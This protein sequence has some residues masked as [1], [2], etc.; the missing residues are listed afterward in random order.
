M[1]LVSFYRQDRSPGTGV[2]LPTG[3]ILDLQAVPGGIPGDMAALLGEPALLERAREALARAERHPEAL[4]DGGS[5]AWAPAVP[6]PGKF[7]LCGRNY[8][9]HA[10]E[11]GWAPPEKPALFGR[12]ASSLLGAGQPIR[13]PRVDRKVDWEGELVAVIGRAGRYIGRADAMQHVAGLTCFN[14]VSMRDYQKNLPHVTL[15]KNFDASG[16]LGPWVTTL[17]E[18][19]DPAALTLRTL[20][21]GEVVQEG[22]TRDLIFDLPSLIELISSAMTLRPGD[23]ITTGTPAGVGYARTPPRYLQPG[24]SVTVS[25]SGVGELTNPVL[26][27]EDAGG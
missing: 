11:M 23:L 3:R 17:D 16:P 14:D 7:V 10:K 12:F 27:E 4:L 22:N 20:V 24:D 25:V 18:I 15:G 26:D 21:N 8:G 19:P 9:T 1:K 5:I 6:A 13:V 2:A